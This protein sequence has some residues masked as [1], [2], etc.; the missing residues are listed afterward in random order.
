MAGNSLQQTQAS[1][2]LDLPLEFLEVSIVYLPT[3]Q[4]VPNP[5]RNYMGRFRLPQNMLKNNW[6]A[7][8]FK[9]LE[10]AFQVPV[11]L[12]FGG[13]WTDLRYGRGFLVHGQFWD[14]NPHWE[15]GSSWDLASTYNSAYG[16]N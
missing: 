7:A 2:F 5:K 15:G 13:V 1:I 4:L 3:Q 14:L 16:T 8:G 11:P 10:A 9:A 12:C 6:G